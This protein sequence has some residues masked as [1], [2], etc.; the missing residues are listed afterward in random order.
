MMVIEIAGSEHSIERSERRVLRTGHHIMLDTEMT[1]KQESE[2]DYNNSVKRVERGYN[3]V[4]QV[5][6]VQ[7]VF[8]LLKDH[9]EGFGQ[10]S[11]CR[12]GDDE[13]SATEMSYVFEVDHNTETGRPKT[14]LHVAK[15]YPCQATYT[16][17]PLVFPADEDIIRR[18]TQLYFG[19]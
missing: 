16:A 6:S 2:E 9:G 17:I 12:H 10:D 18:A 7:D 15:G 4:R 11:I 1:L 14:I 19:Q 3:L 13:Q 5:K 8:D